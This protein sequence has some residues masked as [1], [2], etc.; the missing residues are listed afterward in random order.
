MYRVRN[1]GVLGNITLPGVHRKDS[2][3]VSKRLMRT[4]NVS[5]MGNVMEELQKNRALII[6]SG[7]EVMNGRGTIKSHGGIF[8]LEL[9]QSFSEGL[10][11]GA[12]RDV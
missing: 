1:R 2:I 8:N 10:N 6:F 9:I 5:L 12:Q 7:S 11:L 3:V 4:R